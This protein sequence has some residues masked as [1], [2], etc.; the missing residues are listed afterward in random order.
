LV[1]IVLRLLRDGDDWPNLFNV[2]QPI[3]HFAPAT[4]NGFVI[5]PYVVSF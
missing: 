5:I 1:P 2:F 3:F 4:R